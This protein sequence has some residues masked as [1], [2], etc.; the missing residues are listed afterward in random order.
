[1][2]RSISPLPARAA[3]CRKYS[4]RDLQ[5]ALRMLEKLKRGEDIRQAKIPRVKHGVARNRYDQER[6]VDFIL[7]RV[8][9]DLI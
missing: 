9:D 7:D 4:T 3:T 2:C 6:K 8:L 1:M 5:L